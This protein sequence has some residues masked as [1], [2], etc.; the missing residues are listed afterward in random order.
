MFY[1]NTNNVFY[2]KIMN[3]CKKCLLQNNCST[4]CQ[5]HDAYI[6]TWLHPSVWFIICYMIVYITGI[7][8]VLLE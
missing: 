4:P 8:F 7:I 1:Y 2:M 6:T 5:D 3:P